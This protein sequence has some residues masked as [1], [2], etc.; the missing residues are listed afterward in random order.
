MTNFIQTK[1]IKMSDWGIDLSAGYLRSVSIRFVKVRKGWTR[2]VLETY[3]N[4]EE[5]QN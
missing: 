4:I 3:G 1:H 2:N 5:V